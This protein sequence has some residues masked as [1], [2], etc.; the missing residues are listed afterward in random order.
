MARS[1]NYTRLELEGERKRSARLE[2]EL[3]AMRDQ[4]PGIVECMQAMDKK[5][6]TK[7]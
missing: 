7:R 1:L 6:R 3:Q 5:R 2:S 4:A